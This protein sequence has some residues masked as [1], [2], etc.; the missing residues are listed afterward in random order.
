MACDSYEDDYHLTPDDWVTEDRRP[1]NA[2]ETWTLHKR[3][4]PPVRTTPLR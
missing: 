2:V 4:P 1:E 3:Y